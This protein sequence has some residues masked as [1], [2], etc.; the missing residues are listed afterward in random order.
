MFEL[1]ASLH[2]LN[3][4]SHNSCTPSIARSLFF[5]LDWRYY[6]KRASTLAAIIDGLSPTLLKIA[7]FLA[8]QSFQQMNFGSAIHTFLIVL[9]FLNDP[10]YFF[11]Q[12]V[13]I[14]A[15]VVGQ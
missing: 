5:I 11:L 3:C 14:F 4:F 7:L 10:W 9:L 2:E 6:D 8:N 13:N 15:H 12:K 1:E